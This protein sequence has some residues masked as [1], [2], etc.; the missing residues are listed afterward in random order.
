MTSVI[1]PTDYAPGSGSALPSNASDL[2]RA[3]DQLDGERLTGTVPGLAGTGG[4]KRQVPF[5]WDADNCP[6][7]F[8]PLLAWAFRLDFFDSAWPESF[9]RGMV[10]NARRIN[11]LR[12]TVAGL[13]LMLQL[14]GHPNAQVIESPGVPRRGQGLLRDGTR[15][16][17]ATNSWALFS[18]VLTNPI[19][20]KQFEI[21]KNAVDRVK[22]NCCW[23]VDFEQ[24]T[25]PL[26]RGL[27]HLRGQGKVRGTI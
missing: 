12:G 7:E 18:I 1:R 3:L 9:Q 2:E 15:Q 8:L 6:L 11:Q 13:K 4:L 21:L 19:S 27:G 23:L 5:L 26:L 16:R 22:R 20:D 24:P 10:K 17:T 25:T 14:L